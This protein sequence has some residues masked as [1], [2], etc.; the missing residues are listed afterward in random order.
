MGGNGADTNPVDAVSS[1]KIEENKWK[2]LPPMPTARYATFSF[3]I[4]DKLY[5]IGMYLLQFN[6]L[7]FVTDVYLLL[8]NVRLFYQLLIND[9][10]KLCVKGLCL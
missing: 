1:I 9:K 4:D 10:L 2:A 3:L 6:D 5:V 8:I 7:L